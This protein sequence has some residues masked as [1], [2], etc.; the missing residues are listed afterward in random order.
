M[1]EHLVELFKMSFIPDYEKLKHVT[2][3]MEE[4]SK[5]PGIKKIT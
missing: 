4:L 1:Q 2:M 3:Q 5:Q